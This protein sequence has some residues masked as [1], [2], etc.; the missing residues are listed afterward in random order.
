MEFW[1][2]FLENVWFYMETLGLV[3]DSM[4][5]INSIWHWPILQQSKYYLHNLNF[6][7][8]LLLHIYLQKYERFKLCLTDQTFMQLKY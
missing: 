2:Y 4:A 3:S 1:K 5:A 7:L 8:S 6:V